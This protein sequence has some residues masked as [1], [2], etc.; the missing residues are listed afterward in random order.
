MNNKSIY[1]IYD[2]VNCTPNGDPDNGE[3][4]Y[5]EITKKVTVTDLRIKRFGRDKL[6]S[7]GVPVFYFY[8][9]ETIVVDG[10]AK[11][12]AAARFAAFCKEKGIVMGSKKA[13]K[14]KKGEEPAVSE[15]TPTSFD[16]S[17]ILLQNFS[18]VRMFGGVL[19][20]K[21]NNAHITGALQ[22]DAENDSLNEVIHG[23]NLV[24]RGITTVFPSKDENGQGSMGRDSYLRY[25]VFCI[26]GHM[27]ATNAKIN[28][29]TD[30][31]LKLT[32]TA[33]W[34]GMKNATSRSKYGHE[35]IACI[36]I[37]HP[38]KEVNNGFLGT[39][40]GKSFS[41]MVIKTNNKLSDI[42]RREDYEFDFT[43]LKNAAE[44]KQVEK[45]TIYCDNDDFIQKHFS[46]L[47]SKCRV[48]NPLDELMNL[49]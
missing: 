41:P 18:D 11:S 22:F 48:V 16:S 24:N 49:V 4:R 33:I 34:D 1:F 43:P 37:D 35:P 7:L 25:A 40:F 3:Q 2:A 23:K 42:Y 19:T 32:L 21:E 5:N 8:D 15:E 20:S 14:A 12:G 45:V 6:H 47:S 9:K 36:V 46:N 44:T 31:D 29:A 26:K 39:I 38:T 30:E 13:K 17:V 10:E 28:G 27:S